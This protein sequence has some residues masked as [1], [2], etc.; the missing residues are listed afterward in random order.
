M[1]KNFGPLVITYEAIYFISLS[2]ILTSSK[3]KVKFYLESF[4]GSSGIA[5]SNRQ[6][7]AKEKAKAILCNL[8]E[9]SSRLDNL[10]LEYENS[11]KIN[12]NEIINCKAKG[13]SYRLFAI[14]TESKSYTFDL[15]ECSD[16]LN[17]G[18]IEINKNP[19][20]KINNAFFEFLYIN[21][22]PLET[23]FVE[24]MKIR[25]FI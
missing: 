5:L 15:L 21:N 17:M 11:I 6:T 16:K 22:Y 24:K 3:S 12:K 23:K 13:F 8:G 20:E 18:D 10:I 2:Q 1:E 7:E 14:R 19:R 25:K 4:G 9:I